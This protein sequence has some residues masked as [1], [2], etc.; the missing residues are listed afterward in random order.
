MTIEGDKALEAYAKSF[1]GDYHIT[2]FPSAYYDR[3]LSR[4]GKEY[5]EVRLFDSQWQ[6]PEPIGDK[7]AVLTFAKG[8]E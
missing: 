1:S 5:V 6:G 3:L 7:T 2:P 4:Y 8:L